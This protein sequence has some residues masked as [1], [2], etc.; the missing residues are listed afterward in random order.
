MKCGEGYF[1]DPAGAL[2]SAERAGYTA[3]T[4][5]L[6]YRLDSGETI[7]MDLCPLADHEGGAYLSE[8]HG[9]GESAMF[10]P[11]VEGIVTPP[12]A[13]R[14]LLSK[15]RERELQEELEK[16]T[17]GDGGLL[18][19]ANL[20]VAEAII[21]EALDTLRDE[22]SAIPE[23][24]VYSQSRADELMRYVENAYLRLT[25]GDTHPDRDG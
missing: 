6:D 23:Y 19:P 13:A 1:M 25:H 10:T 20:V 3:R 9:F 14:M 17:E 2:R 5:R 18:D 16:S 4:I 12:D 15:Q 11:D 8:I 7:T 21:S 24:P 22:L